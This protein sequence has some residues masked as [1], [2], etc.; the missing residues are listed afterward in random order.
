MALFTRTSP[1]RGPRPYPAFRP[2]VRAD[3]GGCCGYC[4]LHEFWAGGE[5]NFELDHYKPIS[6]FP[7]LS[8]DYLNLYYACHVCNQ[9]KRDHW[10]PAVAC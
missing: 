10:P 5:R 1:P 8:S 6:L 2:F 9:L 4:L 7:E 3:F